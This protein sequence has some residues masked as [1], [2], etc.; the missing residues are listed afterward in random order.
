[1]KGCKHY[2]TKVV[3]AAAG[4]MIAPNKPAVYRNRHDNMPVYP[5]PDAKP[6]KPQPRTR[7]VSPNNPITR[8]GKGTRSPKA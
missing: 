2:P 7:M 1:M 8:Q 6:G 5:G 4:G 3:K